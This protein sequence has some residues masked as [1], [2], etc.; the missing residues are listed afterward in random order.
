MDL[1]AVRPAGYAGRVR[2]RDTA[3]DIRR[4]QFDIYRAMLPAQRVE[5]A[6]A[7][8]Q[9]VRQITLDGI[10]ARNPSFDDAQVHLEWLRILYGDGFA[11]R[12]AALRAAP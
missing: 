1:G 7:M 12:L 6:V 9:D 3:P 11:A 4:R 8:S 5:L 2:L 10:R